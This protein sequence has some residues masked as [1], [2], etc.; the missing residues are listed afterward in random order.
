M[1]QFMFLDFL[2]RPVCF[3]LMECFVNLSSV[4]K[5]QSYLAAIAAY[6]VAGGFHSLHEIVAPA[7]YALGL[8]PGYNVSVPTQAQQALPPNFH[9]FY[10]QLMEH[11]PDFKLVYEEGW[12]KNS[13]NFSRKIFANG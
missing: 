3:C 6:I 7:E 10:S 5:K 1:M 4:E 8:V 12:R 2:G 9:Q 11:D 13:S